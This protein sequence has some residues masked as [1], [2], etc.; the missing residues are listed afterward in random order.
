MHFSVNSCLINYALL[1][2]MPRI[3]EACNI[4]KNPID[5]LLYYRFALVGFEYRQ[6]LCSEYF[7]GQVHYAL[8]AMPGESLKACVVVESCHTEYSSTSI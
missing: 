1:F 2:A 6:I 8:F 4:A 3:L 7:F 5:F